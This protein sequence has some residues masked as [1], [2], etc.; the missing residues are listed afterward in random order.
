MRYMICNHDSEVELDM[1]YGMGVI[2]RNQFEDNPARYLQDGDQLIIK[3]EIVK[4]ENKILSHGVCFE[5]Y[6]TF[7]NA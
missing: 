7:R 5:I 4:L 6:V 3:I 2:L 1:N